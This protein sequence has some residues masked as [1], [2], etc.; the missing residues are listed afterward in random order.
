MILQS[1][2]FYQLLLAHFLSD[3]TFQTNKVFAI[4]IKYSWGVSLHA[5]ICGLTWLI[6]SAPYLG[7]PAM[8]FV[9]IFFGFVMHLL[10][11]KGKMVLNKFLGRDSIWFFIL[12]QILHFCCAAAIVYFAADLKPASINPVLDAFFNNSHWIK[13]LTWYVVGTY[14]AHIFVFMIKI[15]YFAKYFEKVLLPSTSIKYAGILERALMATFVWWGG[16]YLI[17]VPVAAIPGVV[18]SGRGV[19][20]TS[21]IDSMLSWAMA[22]GVGIG[23]KFV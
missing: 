5:L 19:K 16:W 23:L 2:L 21:L 15:N 12:D 20:G 8:W 9:V 6:M 22:L 1:T 10:I 13:V 14:A 17:F 3:Y 4:K 7:S 18:L 11:D